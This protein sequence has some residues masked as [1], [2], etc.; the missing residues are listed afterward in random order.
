[1]STEDQSPRFRLP[2]WK[3]K[4]NGIKMMAPHIG[5]TG[6]L[7]VSVCMG[8]IATSVDNTAVGDCSVKVG[9]AGCCV[10]VGLS[11]GD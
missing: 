11:V 1:M 8:V 5:K 10:W 9:L 2:L 4:V 3:T 7:V 6:L